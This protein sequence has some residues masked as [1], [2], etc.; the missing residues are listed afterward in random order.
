MASNTRSGSRCGLF[1]SLSLCLS[2]YVSLSP[3]SDCV[4][5][6]RHDSTV[7]DMSTIS[8][9]LDQCNINGNPA[10]CCTDQAYAAGDHLIPKTRTI[11]AQNLPPAVRAAIEAE[12]AA[13]MDGV[14]H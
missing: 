10:L 9:Q 8:E 6:R 14:S 3:L 12:D 13:N 7:Y 5:C 2:L 1:L 11:T 4:M